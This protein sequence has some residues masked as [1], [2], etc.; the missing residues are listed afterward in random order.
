MWGLRGVFLFFVVSA[1]SFGAG[2]IAAVLADHCRRAQIAV[3]PPPFVKLKPKDLH[4]ELG[5]GINVVYEATWP[6]GTRV[7]VKVPQAGEKPHG[8]IHDPTTSI[9][10][11]QEGELV[12]EWHPPYSPK[13]FGFVQLPDGR[14]GFAME[15]M[16]KGALHSVEDGPKL[17]ELVRR[18]PELAPELGRQIFNR[19]QAL[20][21]KGHQDGD[22]QYFVI[23]TPGQKPLVR[24]VFADHSEYRLSEV[25]AGG[26][27]SHREITWVNQNGLTNALLSLGPEGAYPSLKPYL[28]LDPSPTPL[29]GAK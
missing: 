9:S 15:L 13:I 23:H 7:A 26:I 20:N 12:S 11:V 28:K 25:R 1:P 19:Y 24:V 17:R 18:N 6:D 8:D 4:G 3:A 2:P 10:P 27:D 5:S 21:E 14:Q 29:V 22:D 16:P